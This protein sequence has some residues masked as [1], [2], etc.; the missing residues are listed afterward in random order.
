MSYSDHT[1]TAVLVDN[2]AQHKFPEDLIKG[3]LEVELAILH[4]KHVS[5]TRLTVDIDDV[6]PLISMMK[7]DSLG[8]DEFLSS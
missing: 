3:S 5:H 7:I 2:N 4:L 6:M 1:R 8:E